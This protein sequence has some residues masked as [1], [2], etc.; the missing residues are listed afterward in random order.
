MALTN[1]FVR[2]GPKAMRL[3]LAWVM[4]CVGT[5]ITNAI[6]F[7]YDPC[8]DKLQLICS[9]DPCPKTKRLWPK[10]LHMSPILHNWCHKFLTKQIRDRNCAEI[11]NREE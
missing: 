7:T 5:Y 6:H 4:A 11:L 9:N 10:K 2:R 3:D 8:T 1:V